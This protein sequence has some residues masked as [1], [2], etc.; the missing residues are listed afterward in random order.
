MNSPKKHENTAGFIDLAPEDRLEEK[1]ANTLRKKIVDSYKEKLKLIKEL[2]KK[3]AE[4][5]Q[6]D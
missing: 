1:V 4:L 3:K 6:E 5:L 2:R